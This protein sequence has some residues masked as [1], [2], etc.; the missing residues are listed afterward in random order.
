MGTTATNVNIQSTVLKGMVRDYK[1]GMPVT[2]LGEKYGLK[3][4]KVK[5]V[6][7]QQGLSRRDRG[8]VSYNQRFNSMVAALKSGKSHA[9]IAEQFGLSRSRVSEIFKERNVVAAQVSTPAKQAVKAKAAPA[10]KAKVPRTMKA[11]GMSREEYELHTGLHGCSSNPGSPMHKY[12]AHKSNARR[13]G[14]EWQFNFKDWW[15]MWV[16]SGRWDQRGPGCFVLGRK[17]WATTLMSPQ[18]CHVYYLPDVLAYA[19]R[20]HSLTKGSA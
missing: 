19:P 20:A 3:V 15:R 2:D 9:Q 6:L 17:D 4:H 10:A 14:L 7:N 13:N 18:T 11:W 1:K 8:S 12:G 16:E 5:S